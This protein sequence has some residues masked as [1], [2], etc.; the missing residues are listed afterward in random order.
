MNVELGPKRKEV[1]Y[2]A[3]MAAL[4]PL[5]ESLESSTSH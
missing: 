1:G 2:V 4:L 3:S 5:T